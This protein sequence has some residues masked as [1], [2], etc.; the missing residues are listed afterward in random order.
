[1]PPLAIVATRTTCV[2]TLTRNSTCVTTLARNST[3][4][5]SD[6][7]SKP[8]AHAATISVTTNDAVAAGLTSA[9]SPATVHSTSTGSARCSTPIPTW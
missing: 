2:T 8:A 7:S 4:V 3:I 9:T 6:A 5:A 1:M